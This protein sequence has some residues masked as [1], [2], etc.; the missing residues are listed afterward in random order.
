MTSESAVPI[1]PAKTPGNVARGW[2]WITAA[3]G[4][5][6][7]LVVSCST[8][9]LKTPA[10]PTPNPTLTAAPAN[11]TISATPTITLTASVTRTL[12][13]TRTGTP[14]MGPHTIQVDVASC[15]NFYPACPLCGNFPYDCSV[16]S[17]F[18]L[19][20]AFADPASGGPPP[21][22]IVATAAGAFCSGPNTFNVFLNGV[23]IVNVPGITGGCS[24]SSVCDSYAQDSGNV[25]SFPGWAVGGLNTVT[26]SMVAGNLCLQRIALTLYYN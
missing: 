16:R 11:I 14:A 6:L 5:C 3:T 2:L 22:R 7:L 15:W 20:C 8:T 21:Y 19:S 12:T 4:A 24:C 25:G 10:S 26:I 9:S 17:G 23:A 13:A 1:P 18:P